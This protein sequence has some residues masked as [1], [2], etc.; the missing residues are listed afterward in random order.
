MKK[1]RLLIVFLVLLCLLPSLGAKTLDEII[2]AA[3]KASPS[4][5]NVLLTYQNG[6][7]S[8]SSLEEEDKVGV[9]V[10][11][12][13]DPLADIYDKSSSSDEYDEM[14]DTA[15]IS[16]LTSASSDDDSNRGITVSPSVTVTLPNDGNTKISGGATISSRYND[17]KTSVSGNVGVSHTFDFSGY[18]EDHSEDLNYTSTKYSTE[19]TYKESELTFR[20]SVMST[21]SSIIS[22]EST[23]QQSEYNVSKQQKAVDKIKALGTY[24]ETSAT[25]LNAVNVLESY[26][27]SY[28]ASKEQYDNLLTTYKTLTGLEWDGVEGLEA[29]VLELKVY[30]NGNTS[31][32]I[33]SLS[34]ESSEE[35]YKRTL[36]N[37][38]PSK[39][40]TSINLSASDSNVYGISGTLTYIGNN[41]SVSVTP[42]VNI[43]SGSTKPSV[44]ITGSWS[45]GAG[46]SMVVTD[47][48]E[49]AA[50]SVSGSS[51]N[52]VKSALNNAQMAQNSY[53][54]ALSSYNEEAS[55]YALQILQWNSKKSQKEAELEYR[56][57][58]LDNEQSLYD[59]GLTTSDSLEEAKMNYE[60]CQKEWNQVILEG[61][62]LEC[63]LEIFAL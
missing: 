6:L 41:W 26:K 28:E 19:K 43:S 17:G 20:K 46:S 37:A 42:G 10:S 3:E 4:Y 33:K 38:T 5:K 39:L 34:A 27:S 51:A 52:A 18:S 59:L 25:Y 53:L 44:T 29:P 48:E 50:Y 12:T 32:L 2:E 15:A 61:L 7:L 11:A 21:I 47:D 49:G 31:V 1:N 13:V 36:A 40:S 24:S 35:T 22:L 57:T 14:V 56:K 9:S 63:D 62:S 30:E 55:S 60:L 16:K 58:L 23:L 45:N 8:I 54:E